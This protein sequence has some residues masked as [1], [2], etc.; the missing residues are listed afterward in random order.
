VLPDVLLN[1]LRKHREDE[2]DMLPSMQQD[3]AEKIDEMF[4]DF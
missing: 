3:A 4:K 2:K 1:T